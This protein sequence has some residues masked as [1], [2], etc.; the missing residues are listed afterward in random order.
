[1]AAYNTFESFGHSMSIWKRAWKLDGQILWF[2]SSLHFSGIVV[3][4]NYKMIQIFLPRKKTSV[5][6][7]STTV[8]HAVAAEQDALVQLR[9]YKFFQ[10]WSFCQFGQELGYFRWHL[11]SLWVEWA[12]IDIPIAAAT[13]M[14]I[15]AINVLEPDAF[16]AESQYFIPLFN[17]TSG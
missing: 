5:P 2:T 11:K 3:F 8:F 10:P 14:C 1:M 7:F 15:V 12:Q 17:R 13:A 6:I 4:W 16:N 9:V